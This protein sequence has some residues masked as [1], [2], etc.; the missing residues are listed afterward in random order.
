VQQFRRVFVPLAL[1]LLGALS[2]SCSST[3][4]S[5]VPSMGVAAGPEMPEVLGRFITAEHYRSLPAQ[6]QRML[7]NIAA[8]PELTHG[9]AACFAE[10]TPGEVMSAFNAVIFGFQPR[11]NQASRWGATA[12]NPGG[13]Q[14]PNQPTIVTYSFVPD[15]TPI[16]GFNGEPAAPSDMFAFFNGIYG[17]PATWQAHFHSIFQRW[18]QLCGVTYVFE[19]NDDS[20]SLNSQPGVA[21]VRGDVRIGGHFIDGNSGVL[22]YNFY[23][24]GGDMVLDTGDNFYTN[25]GTNSLRL[26]N[27]LAHEHGHGMGQAHVCPITQ[28]KLMEPFISTAYDGPRHDDIRN[29]Q[30][31]YGD[32]YE[33][34]GSIATATPIGSLAIGGN[35]SI[36]AVPAPAITLGATTSININ[37]DNDYYRVSVPGATLL[38]VTVTPVG[39]NYED[40]PQS[41]SG[42]TGSCCSGTF[43]DSLSTANLNVQVIGSNGSTVLA[44]AAT[45]PAGQ[46]ETA[47]SV[48]L[49]A[50]G[51]YYV[52]VYGASAASEVQ[53]YTMTLSSSTTGLNIDLPAGTPTEVAPSTP[54][55]FAVTITALG[56]TVSSASLFYRPVASG[57]YL[58]VPLAHNG[59]T[60]YTATIPGLPC[61][62]TPQF[63]VQATGSGGTTVRSPLNAPTTVYAATVANT[64]VQPLYDNFETDQ[65][66]SVVNGAGLTSGAWVRVDPVGTAAQPENDVSDPGTHCY[67]TGQGAVG[68]GLGDADVDG[69]DTNLLSPVFDLTGTAS[70]RV[71]YWR[72]YSNNTGG[73]PNSD[74]MVISASANG[75]TSWTTIETVGPTTQNTGGWLFADIPFT[76]ARTNNMRLRFTASDLGA[77]S[78]VEA[79]VDEV[80]VTGRTCVP[81]SGGCGTADFDGDG[82]VGTDADIEAFFACLAG[83]CCPT[84][85]SG[86]ADFNGDGDVGTDADIEAFFRVLAGGPC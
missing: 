57:G 79:A 15:G 19:P 24:Q 14:T 16:S 78:L 53:L 13:S 85:F 5:S 22:A 75:G 29:A 70:A 32:I 64:D 28:S 30:Q 59:G 35:L 7:D 73:A 54:E 23:P 21:G 17:S 3:Q 1:G 37:N 60:S 26:R 25:T 66:W 77:G 55:A 42:Q 72:W 11:F 86:G 56:Q 18:G 67:V 4:V 44:T 20:A 33:P 80:R 61:G 76:I 40:A 52:R 82:D 68:G 84:C 36:G 6:Y 2:L 51:D 71:S 38:T 81:V 47:S 12:Q 46:A 8:D 58:S 62:S 10:D 27:V 83:N 39:V 43:T 48:Q 50:A 69:G 41:C 45:S 74:T 65:G 31:H 63:Y 9:M 49:P 34:N